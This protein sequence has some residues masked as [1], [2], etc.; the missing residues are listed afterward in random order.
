MISYD[1]EPPG[2]VTS[3]LSPNDFPMRALAVGDVIDR[4]IIFLDQ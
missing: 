3:T 2:V 1:F 4:Q